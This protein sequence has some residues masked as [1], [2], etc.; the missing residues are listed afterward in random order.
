MLPTLK[1]WLSLWWKQTS[2]LDTILL[3]VQNVQTSCPVDMKNILKASQIPCAGIRPSTVSAMM[4]FWPLS[5]VGVVS[6][7]AVTVVP[8][9]RI[10][11]W[12]FQNRYH[13]R[14]R[15]EQLVQK[16]ENARKF[17]ILLGTHVRFQWWNAVTYKCLQC[18]KQW[19]NKM[20]A[21]P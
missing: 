2:Y 5:A 19:F 4:F 18:I 17:N 12:K 1:R 8:S 21:A 6:M 7:Q 15:L 13:R 10:H 11:R 16:Q 9:W 3:M 20:V 14:C